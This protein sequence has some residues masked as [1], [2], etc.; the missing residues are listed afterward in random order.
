MQAGLGS[1]ELSQ[2]RASHSFRFTSWASAL[3]LS[4]SLSLF[5]ASAGKFPPPSPARSSSCKSILRVWSRSCGARSF[6]LQLLSKVKRSSSI[7][8]D[9]FL[10]VLQGSRCSTVGTQE[11]SSPNLSQPPSPRLL[12]SSASPF[13]P[14]PT[15]PLNSHSRLS[16]QCR[17]SSSVSSDMGAATASG[18]L[19]RHSDVSVFQALHATPLFFN[20][21]FSLDSCSS[22]PY[23]STSEMKHE[24]RFVIPDIHRLGAE[25]ASKAHHSCISRLG[26]FK[27]HITIIHRSGTKKPNPCPDGSPTPCSLSAGSHLMSKLK[28]TCG[29]VG[30]HPGSDLFVGNPF[31]TRVSPAPISSHEA[32]ED[33]VIIPSQGLLHVGAKDKGNGVKDRLVFFL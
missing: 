22:H 3:S 28:E 23:H 21:R 18:C 2:P 17:P 5:M 27:P 9:L 4:L 31:L 19:R 32:V 8:K 25:S 20:R 12:P 1:W 16:A 26:S 14:A 15:P 24:D 13:S 11:P 6:L 10:F 33:N 7:A 29:Q 30:I